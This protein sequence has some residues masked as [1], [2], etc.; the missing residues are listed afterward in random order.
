[1]SRIGPRTFWMLLKETA[2]EWFSDPVFRL[3]GALSYFT[4]FSLAPLLIIVLFIIGLFWGDQTSVAQARILGEIRDMVGADGAEMVET[5]LDNA[6]RSEDRGLWAT[7]VGVGALLL[8]STGVFVQLK[9]ALNTIWEAEPTSGSGL[10]KLIVVRLLAIGMI[11]AVG[12][13][14]LVSLIIS[15]GLSAVDEFVTGLAPE[16]HLLF[17]VINIAV[18]FG[19]ITL[20][21]A[22]LYRYLPDVEI[23]WQEV[24]IGAAITALLFN[25]GKLGIGLYLGN[26]AVMS[27]YGAAGSLAVLLLWIYYSSL[28]VFFGA[29]FTQVYAR[30]FGHRAEQPASDDGA[31]VR[32]YEEASSP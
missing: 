28:I 31:A 7:L 21:F 8:G 2:L 3:S 9:G 22:I 26:S 20:L 18:S 30:H 5:M 1:M 19:L 13:L 32:M 24:W 14:L 12:F 16:F 15:A 10:K 4:V 27:T 23:A 17:R 29:E 25:L 11:L 6:S